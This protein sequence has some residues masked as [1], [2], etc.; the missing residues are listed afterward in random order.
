MWVVRWFRFYFCANKIISKQTI[1][2]ICF[3]ILSSIYTY[4]MQYARIHVYMFIET[5][6]WKYHHRMNEYKCKIDLK[7]NTVK[8]EKHILTKVHFS[9]SCGLES[10]LHFEVFFSVTSCKV[11]RQL[12]FNQSPHNELESIQTVEMHFHFCDTF[13]QINTNSYFESSWFLFNRTRETV[14]VEKMKN[15]FK[16]KNETF[17]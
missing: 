3:D 17:F 2:H 7:S 13:R 11:H 14:F 9:H 5:H 12:G 1:T 4:N 15:I 6:I 8:N 16:P 10:W